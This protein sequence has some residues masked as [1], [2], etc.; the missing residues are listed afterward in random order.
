[1]CS[2][3]LSWMG[4]ALGWSARLGPSAPGQLQEGK[5]WAERPAGRGTGTRDS[6]RG[7]EGPA[8]GGRC[9]TAAPQKVWPFLWHACRV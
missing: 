6:C 1:M 7:P 2:K 9:P 4:R 8:R 5:V 3:R